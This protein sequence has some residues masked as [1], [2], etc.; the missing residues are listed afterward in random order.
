MK[1][2]DPIRSAVRRP[3]RLT[4]TNTVYLGAALCGSVSIALAAGIDLGRFSAARPV[5][6]LDVALAFAA[7]LIFLGGLLWQRLR[8]RGGVS[9]IRMMRVASPALLPVERG[10]AAD[11][12]PRD[13]RPAR[14]IRIWSGTGSDLFLQRGTPLFRLLNRA[15]DISVILVNPYASLH[16]LNDREVQMAHLCA[17]EEC[18]A[19]L[20]EL[21]AGGRNVRLRFADE[22]PPWNM[23]IVGDRVWIRPC[24]PE[25]YCGATDE[26]VFQRDGASSAQ[27]LYGLFHSH[28][29]L[30]WDDA[31]LPE[32]DFERREILYRNHY[33]QTTAALPLGRSRI[34]ASSRKRRTLRALSEPVSRAIWPKRRVRAASR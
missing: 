21:R 33:G 2:E 31:A 12:T 24:A 15:Q 20:G 3:N 7:I 29:T 17:I 34:P 30:R 26:Y 18:A 28:F 14:E 23:A 5:A 16:G 27:G 6:W 10:S 1:A 32:Y 9:P 4:K 19:R 22:L 8:F 11:P 13:L 25:Q